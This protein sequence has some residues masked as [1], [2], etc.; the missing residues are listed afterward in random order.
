[1]HMLDCHTFILHAVGFHKHGP[2]HLCKVLL[3]ATSGVAQLDK[4][5]LTL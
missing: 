4:I 3:V 1:M 5:W 2:S